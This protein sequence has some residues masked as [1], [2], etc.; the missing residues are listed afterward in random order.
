MVAEEVVEEEEALVLICDGCETE[1][2]YDELYPDGD[3]EI[4]EG[5]WFCTPCELHKKSTK[6]T[7]ATAKKAASVKKAT[8][9]VKGK[10]TAAAAVEEAP[11]R[12]S[13]RK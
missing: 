13:R 11:K 10:N 6:C 9:P 4:P 2:F 8:A 5:D 7:K 1:F 3:F 12:S